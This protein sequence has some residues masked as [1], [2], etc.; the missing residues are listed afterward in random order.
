M[1]NPQKSIVI[2]QIL[3]DATPTSLVAVVSFTHITVGN[4]LTLEETRWR[5]FPLATSF[6]S[7]LDNVQDIFNQPW[8]TIPKP[9]VQYRRS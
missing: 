8:K 3:L 7:V 6:I 4:P 5:E 2:T 9:I 1:S